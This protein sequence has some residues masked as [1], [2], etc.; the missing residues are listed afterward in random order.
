LISDFIKAINFIV[1]LPVNFIHINNNLMQIK[2]II[3]VLEHLAPSALQEDYDNAGLITGSSDWECQG[4]VVSLDATEDVVNEAIEKNCNLIIA[5]H[6]IVFKGIK[7]INGK[8]YVE[9][10]IITAV[11]NDI[12][13]YAIH[14]NLDNVIHGVNGKIADL[15]GLINRRILAPKSGL[16][17][18]LSVF[19]PLA[20]KTPLMNALFEAGAGNIG[21]YSECSFSSEGS[22]TYLP[23]ANTNP[24]LGKKGQRHEEMEARVEVI[25]PAWLQGKIV[26]AMMVNHPYEEVAYDIYPLV[27]S[28]QETGSGLVGELPHQCTEEE[29]LKQF[30]IIFNIP[31]IKHT[32]LL[33]KPINKVA[34]CGGAGSFLTAAAVASGADMY[35]TGDIKYHEFFDAE[36]K[37][38]LADIGHYE[39]E[40]FTIHL[41]FD[42][43]KGKFPNFAVL[44]TGVNTNPVRYFK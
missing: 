26:R 39:S 28:F 1:S 27:N 14:T 22:G 9:Q 18:K 15:L 13:I 34:L 35:I 23:G 36:G 25:F 32:R 8:N 33:G 24:Y 21:E 42:I 20:H 2:E 17:Q 31:V 19:V 3:A 7:K 4:I 43:L 44:K 16:L 11:K 30:R 37:L 38:L 6:P 10:T 5:H 29:I 12:A 40:Q 41:L